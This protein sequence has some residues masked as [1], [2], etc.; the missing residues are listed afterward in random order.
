MFSMHSRLKYFETGIENRIDY[1]S[2]VQL[3]G[4]ISVGKKV[5]CSASPEACVTAIKDKGK[6]KGTV[7]LSLLPFAWHRNKI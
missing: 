2:F 5:S 4:D 7:T 3:D 6:D 1:N